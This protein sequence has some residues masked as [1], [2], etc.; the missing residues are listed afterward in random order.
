MPLLDLSDEDTAY[1]IKRDAAPRRRRPRPFRYTSHHCTCDET[2]P[3]QC[4]EHQDD[5]VPNR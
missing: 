4:P 5:Y 3:E 2:G 1:E